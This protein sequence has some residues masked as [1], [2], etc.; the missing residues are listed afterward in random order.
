M[1]PMAGLAG[2]TESTGGSPATATGGLSTMLLRP[3]VVGYPLLGSE[4]ILW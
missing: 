1:L 2:E 3:F 4:P